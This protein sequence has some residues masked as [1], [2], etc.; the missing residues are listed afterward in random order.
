[1]KVAI[2]EIKIGDRFREE[3]GDVAGLADS[4]RRFGQLQPII[5]DDDKSLV[6]GFRRLTAAKLV[7]WT[8]IDATFRS[9]MTDVERREVELEENIQRLDM[10]WFE[11]QEAIAE[12][13]RLK[14]LQDPNWSQDMTAAVASTA[15]RP[16]VTEAIKIVKLAKLFPEL[17]GAK[18]LLQAQSWAQAKVASVVRLKEVKDNPAEFKAIEERI[19]L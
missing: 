3:T 2:A 14:C 15:R 6:A 13:H 16:D 5:L 17:K 7:G 19:T 1:M 9:Q 4:F 10:G 11:K 8:D 18:S 12:I